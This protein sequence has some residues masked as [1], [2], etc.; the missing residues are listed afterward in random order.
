MT[1]LDAACAV[2]IGTCLVFS[3][4]LGKK[5]RERVTVNF[6]MRPSEA[7]KEEILRMLRVELWAWLKQQKLQDGKQSHWQ[8]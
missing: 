6:T 5:W 4:W 2:H 7:D 8:L 3:C 1:F